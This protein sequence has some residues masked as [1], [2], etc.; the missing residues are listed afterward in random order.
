MAVL[1]NDSKPAVRR[2]VS[3]KFYA[4]LKKLNAARRRTA[5]IIERHT[6]DGN[7]AEAALAVA[8]ELLFDYFAKNASNGLDLAELNTLAGVI[9]KLSSGE[10]RAVNLKSREGDKGASGG[11]GEE[12]I[13]EIENMLK[14]L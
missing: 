9:Q 8:W 4:H 10:G 14:L 12:G 3:P 1:K 5:E 13:R 7:M 6:K 2:R 11:L